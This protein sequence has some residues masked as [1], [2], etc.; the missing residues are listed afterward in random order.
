MSAADLVDRCH[1]AMGV[2]PLEQAAEDAFRESAR[3]SGMVV[4]ERNVVAEIVA[5]TVAGGELS[6]DD[7]VDALAERREQAEMN[8]AVA[9]GYRAI[10]DELNDTVQATKASNVDRGLVVLRD[11]LSAVLDQARSAVARLGS[12]RTADA[13]VAAGKAEQWKV[14]GELAEWLAD[15]RTA[16]RALIAGTRRDGAPE[17][18]HALNECGYVREPDQYVDVRTW[19]EQR[20]GTRRASPLTGKREDDI[21]PPWLADPV[22]ALLFQARADVKAWLPTMRELSAEHAALNARL[23][24][25]QGEGGSLFVRPAGMA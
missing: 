19:R 12:V 1:E 24:P 6:T 11:E 8:A 3:Y 21:V 13:A 17:R 22:S 2:P 25:A 16:Q 20:D 7:A 9:Q 4:P 23:R 5:A 15:V 10:A 18:V 14:I